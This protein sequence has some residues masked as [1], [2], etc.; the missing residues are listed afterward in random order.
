MNFMNFKSL[1]KFFKVVK[2]LDFEKK[3]ESTFIVHSI[4]TLSFQF[5]LHD[6]AKK[7]SISSISRIM[8]PMNW[9]PKRMLTSTENRRAVTCTNCSNINTSQQTEFWFWPLN[10]RYLKL[11]THVSLKKTRKSWT[12]VLW[13]LPT[14]PTDFPC[15]F[16]RRSTMVTRSSTSR[17]LTTSSSSIVLVSYPQLT[18]LFATT[19]PLLLFVDVFSSIHYLIF[20]MLFCW[21]RILW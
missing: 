14:A 11:Y 4:F 5:Y 7:S 1:S 8:S 15:L 13:T 19:N 18:F 17:P 6:V 9:I 2:T 21:N 12:T 16:G 10:I 3:E 20:D